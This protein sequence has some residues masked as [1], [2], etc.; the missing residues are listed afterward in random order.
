M[1]ASKSYLVDLDGNFQ[2][3]E[4]SADKTIAAGGDQTLLPAPMMRVDLSFPPVAKTTAKRVLTVAYKGIAG[5]AVMV[6][7]P[8]QSSVEI[9]VPHNEVVQVELQDVSHDGVI[10]TPAKLVIYTHPRA[11]IRPLEPS[12]IAVTLVGNTSVQGVVSVPKSVQAAPVEKPEVKPEQSVAPEKPVEAP[13]PVDP[14]K[15]VEP[16]KPVVEPPKPEPKPPQ[17]EKPA[18]APVIPAKPAAAPPKK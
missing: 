14:P 10:G 7:P 1:V 2:L 3:R 4:L 13:K 9:L 17:A 12:P 5:P 18:A 15:V 8:D 6:C 11:R 16:P